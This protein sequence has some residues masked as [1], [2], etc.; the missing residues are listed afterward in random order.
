MGV[1]C[2]HV[3][4]VIMCVCVSCNFPCLGLDLSQNILLPLASSA[5]FDVGIFVLTS[6]RN[7]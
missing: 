1:I 3:Y 4:S 5:S 2:I 7:A 6:I